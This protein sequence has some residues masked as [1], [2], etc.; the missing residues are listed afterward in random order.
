MRNVPPGDEHAALKRVGLRRLHQLQH[1]HVV[2]LQILHLIAAYTQQDR[3][4]P[5]IMAGNGLDT[6]PVWRYIQ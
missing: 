2:D 4:L 1:P 3:V 6:P 5:V